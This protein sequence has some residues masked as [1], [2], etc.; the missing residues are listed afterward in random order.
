MTLRK[1]TLLIIASMFLGAGVILYVATKYILLDSFIELD[2]RRTQQNIERALSALSDDLAYLE[3]TTLDW[4][5]RDDTYAFIEDANQEY[6]KSNLIDGT[7]TE[8]SL[9]L[10]MFINSSGQIVFSKA[11]DLENEEEMPVPQTLR[12]HLSQNDLLLTHP[13]NESSITGII[14]LPESPMLVASGPILTSEEEGP[15]RGTLIMGRYLNFTQIERL[16]K[17]THLS[18]TVRRFTDTQ[19]PADFQAARSFLSE[20]WSYLIRPLDE[21]SIAGYALLKDIYGEPG[22]ILKV[23][24]PRE[25]YQQGQAALNY[26]IWLIFAIGLG[27]AVMTLFFLER[28]VLSRLFHLNDSVSSIGTSGDFSAR[29]P[30]KGKD[31]L[32]SLAGSVND[33][34]AAL[35]QS[36]A[37]LRESE[38]KYKELADSLPQAVFETDEKGNFTFVNR[39]ML[40]SS[41]YTLED[42]DKGIS[43]L[44]VIVPEDRD[45]IGR[46]M[47]LVMSGEEPGSVE[48][49]ALRKDGST[50]PAILFSAPIIR[51][52]KPVGVRGI[53]IDI[54]ERKQAQKKLEELYE[55]ETRMR[56]ELETEMNKKV[57]FTRALVHELK[58]PLTS[59]MASSELLA[60]ESKE[61]PLISLA[62]NI[63]RGASN[64]NNRIGELL[65]L[66]K[67]EVGM[68]QLELKAV[69]LLALLYQVADDMMPVAWSHKQ[70]LT[71]DLPSSLSLVLADEDRL[72]QVLLNLLDNASKFTHEGGK[73]TLRAWEEDSF[74]IVQVQDTGP[75]VAKDELKRLFEPYY[76]LKSESRQLSGLGLGLALCKELVEL[77]GGEIWVES[78][79]GKGSIFSFSLPLEAAEQSKDTSVQEKA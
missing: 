37:E 5:I 73:I 74:A 1:K 58:T 10:M 20:D 60:A 75:G 11:F 65:D 39:Y 33:M 24:M 63:Y 17:Q 64:L 15:I 19:I 3:A 66:A 72:Q 36:Q 48:I 59:V 71:L 35:E 52:G 28:Q 18:L 57:E 32:S 29:V 67:G 13:D 51:E 69:D 77:H 6:I 61:E 9:N 8:L 40:E 21:Q 26:T 12:E 45:R 34:L 78:Q 25:S 14:L 68:L 53:V 47:Q 38:R 22:L 27:F 7:F 2:E 49:T 43:K 79:K 41:G 30:V 16:A 44:Q 23:V 42:F 56:Q 4:S 46:Q 50:F 55:E 62:E 31:E 76:R 54:T 70:S